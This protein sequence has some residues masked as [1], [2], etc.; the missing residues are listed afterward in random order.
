[1]STQD[2]NQNHPE[3]RSINETR[4]GVGVE[5][6]DSFSFRVFIH[7]PSVIL[8]FIAAI[9]GV[10]IAWLSTYL[11]DTPQLI[12]ALAGTCLSFAGVSSITKYINDCTAKEAQNRNQK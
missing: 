7:T 8:G 4:N 10:V 6:P 12:V 9:L 1:M 2:K 11:S 5:V 3:W